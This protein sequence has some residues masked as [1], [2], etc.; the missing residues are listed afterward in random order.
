MSQEIELSCKEEWKG[1]LK[2]CGFA[3]EISVSLT[4]ETC[5][6]IDLM[7][8]SCFDIF[9]LLNLIERLILMCLQVSLRCKIHLVF[10]LYCSDALIQSLAHQ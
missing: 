4:A 10:Y 2:L 3:T 1:L 9:L 7:S 6:H 8:D 5:I